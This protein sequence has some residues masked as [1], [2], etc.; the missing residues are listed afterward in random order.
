MSLRGALSLGFVRMNG[1]FIIVIVEHRDLVAHPGDAVRALQGKQG[2]A[3]FFVLLRLSL[4]RRND[5]LDQR[6][7]L[8]LTSPKTL[9]PVGTF[10]C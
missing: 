7:A 5:E 10:T 3:H 4:F 2:T 1:N 9:L 6:V 8:L